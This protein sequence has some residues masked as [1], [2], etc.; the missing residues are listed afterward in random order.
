MNLGFFAFVKMAAA[1]REMENTGR[2]SQVEIW[3][4]EPLTSSVSTDYRTDVSNNLSTRLIHVSQVDIT[5]GNR[6]RPMIS[7]LN[8]RSA[9]YP[10]AGVAR[11]HSAPDQ[12]PRYSRFLGR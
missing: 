10:L 8:F 6:L 1:Q 9:R 7:G 3:R 12:F 4:H 11:D 2:K 5:G